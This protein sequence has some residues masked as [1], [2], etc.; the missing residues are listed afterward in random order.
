MQLLLIAARTS[1]RC[2]KGRAK[3]CGYG[4]I[5]GEMAALM[6][7]RTAM[8][9][10]DVLRRAVLLNSKKDAFSANLGMYYEDMRRYAS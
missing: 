5:F 6:M 3:E 10:Y 7:L 9:L 2:F 8:I 1:L 4:I